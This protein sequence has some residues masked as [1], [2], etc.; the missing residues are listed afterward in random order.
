MPVT[1]GRQSPKSFAPSH[2]SFT[3]V[4]F[5]Y[6]VAYFTKY[7]AHFP[8]AQFANLPFLHLAQFREGAQGG[9]EVRDSL[10]DRLVVLSDE[11]EV[12]VV[13]PEEEGR[14]IPILDPDYLRFWTRW[15]IGTLQLVPL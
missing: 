9:H 7:L 14:R 2:S 13:R 10:N 12:I 1:I 11:E 8:T 15:S 6:F 5:K 4:L 3:F